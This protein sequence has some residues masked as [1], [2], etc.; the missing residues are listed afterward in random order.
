MS[1]TLTGTPMRASGHHTR[2]STSDATA[3]VIAID[4]HHAALITAPAEANPNASAAN[5]HSNP[6]A[7]IPAVPRSTRPLSTV[8][9]CGTLSVM[10]SCHD[11]ANPTR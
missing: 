6:A 2:L 8:V 9:L 10:D 1:A 11:S 5:S 3:V 7:R 4:T